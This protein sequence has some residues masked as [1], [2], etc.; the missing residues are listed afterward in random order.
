MEDLEQSP[1]FRSN[2]SASTV[3]PSINPP[4]LPAVFTTNFLDAA[5]VQPL[6]FPS[7][8]RTN[9]FSQQSPTSS[10]N[11]DAEKDVDVTYNIP[12]FD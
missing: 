2:P 6:D 10:H 4:S 1:P 9:C 11:S 12:S 8:R 5:V 7:G 3:G